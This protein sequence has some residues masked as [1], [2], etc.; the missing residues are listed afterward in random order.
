MAL[1]DSA[2]GSDSRAAVNAMDEPPTQSGRVVIVDVPRIPS[3]EVAVPSRLAEHLRHVVQE[4]Y[5]IVVLNVEA[6]VHPDSMML[7][8]IVQT[9]VR[10]VKV[11][12]TV[13]LSNVSKKFRDLLAVTKLDKVIEI[14]QIQGDYVKLTA[15]S[16]EPDTR[17]VDA[18]KS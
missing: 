12:G 9:Y 16:G 3:E 14:V 17:K 10:A 4:G 13:K 18:V 6:L 11:G 8:A 1:L 7:A 15:D 5:D 2:V